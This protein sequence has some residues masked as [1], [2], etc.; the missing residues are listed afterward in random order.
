MD[1]VSG[2]VGA[3]P[4]RQT[5]NDSVYNT[6]RAAQDQNILLILNV[7]VTTWSVVDKRLFV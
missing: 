5:T 1:C 7:A 3:T 4:D 6:V 2:G